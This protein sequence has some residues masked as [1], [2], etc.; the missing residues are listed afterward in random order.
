MLPYSP[1]PILFKFYTI[2]ETTKLNENILN[3]PKLQNRVWRFLVPP[4]L[5]TKKKD[6]PFTL[7]KGRGGDWRTY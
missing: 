7:D 1:S 4:F 5:K 2:F 6:F 3:R